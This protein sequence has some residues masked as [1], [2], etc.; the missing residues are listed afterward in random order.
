MADLFH[1]CVSC[2]QHV[3]V[4]ERACPF[5]DAALPEDFG[6]EARTRVARARPISRAAILFVGATAAAACGGS[7]ESGSGD[8]SAHDGSGADSAYDGAVVL[9]GPAPFDASRD[10]NADASAD[11]PVAAYGPGPVD[12]G[13]S[14]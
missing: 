5:C 4:G 11:G 8:A 13:D 12:S 2:A 6:E 10:S 7:T 9:Y 1:P 14:G 3:R